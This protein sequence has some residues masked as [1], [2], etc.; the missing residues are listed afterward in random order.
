MFSVSLSAL[1]LIC[2]GSA[3]QLIGSPQHA[4]SGSPR[5]PQIAELSRKLRSGDKRALALFWSKLRN[6]RTPL[7]ETIPTDSDHHLVTFVWRAE[8]PVENVLLISGLTNESYSRTVLTENLLSRLPGTDVWFRTYR[9]RS[10]ARFTYRFSVNDSLVPS[11]EEKDP[12]KRES[13]FQPDPL[14]TRHFSGP[15]SVSLVEL[16]DAPPQPWIQARNAAPVGQLTK[17]PFRSRIL[18]TERNLTIYT[19]PHYDPVGSTYRLLIVMDAE[20]YT[21]EIPAP[22]ILDNL[23]NAGKI[24]PV[25]AVF[26]ENLTTRQPAAR[27]TE[28]SCHKP[29]ATFLAEELLP[30]IR[31][32]YHVSSVPAQTILGGASRGGLAAVCAALEYPRQFGNVFTQSGF[33]VYKDRN[34]FKNADSASAPDAE[35]Q[36]ELAWEQYGIVMQRVAASARLPLRF[37]LDIGK[38]ENNFHPSPLTANRHLRD[39]LIAK[40]YQVKYQEFAGHHSP[41]NWRGTLSDAL[42][43]LIGSH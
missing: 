14:N 17:I 38:F 30:W 42:L 22:V 28:L 29:F 7:I 41:V 2:L 36:E 24:S 21:S 9:V 8:S 43:F 25:V 1:L 4:S 37:Y 27:T 32:R 11:E 39:V 16:P 33:F 19:P 26:V 35:S 15:S 20:V 12:A 5:S 23:Y 13:R 31:A 10:D 34:W 3:H 6:E 18:G 40:G